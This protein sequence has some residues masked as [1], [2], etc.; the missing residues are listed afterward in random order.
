M[1]PDKYRSDA[2]GCYA[3]RRTAAPSSGRAAP[4]RSAAM[5]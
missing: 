2:T 5:A 3:R 1:P 4:R